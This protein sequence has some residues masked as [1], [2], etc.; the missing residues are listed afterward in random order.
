V[1]GRKTLALAT[2]DQARKRSIGGMQCD[3][4]AIYLSKKG[5]NLSMICN[6]TIGIEHFFKLLPMRKLETR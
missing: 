6:V 1:V 3:Y 5:I 2:A 4:F